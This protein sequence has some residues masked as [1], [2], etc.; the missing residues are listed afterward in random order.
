[1]KLFGK[2]VDPKE[3]IGMTP[4]ELKAKLDSGVTKAELEALATELKNAQA[5]ASGTLTEIKAALAA[6][7]PA[8]AAVNVDDPEDPAVQL[9]ADPKTF[10]DGATKNLREAQQLT[11]AQLEEMRARTKYARIFEKH[12]DALMKFVEKLSVADKAKPGF[13]DWATSTFLG[14]KVLDRTIKPDS[15]PSLMGSSS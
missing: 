3:L 6:L 9:L 5:T 15:F 8:E 13:W 10:V 2:E 7:K 4:E 1:M 11:S 14:S 12:G